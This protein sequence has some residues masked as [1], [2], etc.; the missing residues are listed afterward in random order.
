MVAANGRYYPICNYDQ[1]EN[2]VYCRLDRITDILLLDTPQKPARSIPE[3]KDG[4]N[5]PKHMAEHLYMF[6]G[7]AERV[8]FLAK[9]YLRTILLTG[10]EKIF[11]FWTKQKRKS[12][13]LS[14]SIRIPCDCGPCSMRCM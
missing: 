14:A 13:L 3:L 12:Q 6:P 8:T 2:V 4:L 5:L 10:S 7:K 1:H 9:K 11:S